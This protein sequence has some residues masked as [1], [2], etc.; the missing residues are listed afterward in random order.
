ME[1]LYDCQEAVMEALQAIECEICGSW[2]GAA[3][4]MLCDR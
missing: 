1:F 2:L 3:Y 4:M